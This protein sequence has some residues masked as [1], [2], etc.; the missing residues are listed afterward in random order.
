MGARPPYG[1]SGRLRFGEAL[2]RVASAQKSGAGV[3]AYTR[4]VNRRLAR[5]VAASAASLG[6]SA[7]GVT[8]AS[9]AVSAVGL[10]ILVIAP[11]TWW[12]GPLVACLLALGY[13]L[14]SA[15]GQVSRLLGTSGPAGEWLDHVIDAMRTPLIHVAVFITA[16]GHHG[17]FGHTSVLRYVALAF[18]VLTVGQF[19]SQVLAEQLT[20]RHEFHEVLD[21][22]GGIRQSV[23]LLP[24]DMGVICWM[25]IFWGLP[26]AFPIVY[27]AIFLINLVHTAVSMYR[28]YRTLVSLSPRYG[29]LQ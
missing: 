27:V 3:P 26:A 19:M 18:A 8:I 28:K 20:R 10:L 14:D 9:A 11:I 24:I 1:G 22:R 25:F 17:V 2:S 29:I 4:W 13:V 7:N 5:V 15:D 12:I 21:L 16:T 6:V 23:L